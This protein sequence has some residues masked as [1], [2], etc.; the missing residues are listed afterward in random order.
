M[1]PWYVRAWCSAF[2][3]RWVQ[4]SKEPIIAPFLWCDRCGKYERLSPLWA[5]D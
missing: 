5:C 4:A 3:H 1:P 2:G